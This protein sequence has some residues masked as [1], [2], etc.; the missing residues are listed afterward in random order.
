MF[1]VVV[2]CQEELEHA[3][4][5]GSRF[6]CLCDGSFVLPCTFGI[7]YS[8]I[9]T[10]SASIDLSPIGAMRNNI[11]FSGFTPFFTK[12]NENIKL[13]A[14][15]IYTVCR[16]GSAPSSAS[17]F[18]SSYTT[19]YATSY[20]HEYEYEFEY[21]SGSFLTSYLGSFSSYSSSGSFAVYRD[22]YAH[23]I[24]PDVVF[25]NGYGVNLI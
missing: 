10:V 11:S 25:V 17:S 19:S 4:E 9:G 24:N 1:D 15:P 13:L 21:R 8:A 14:S 18:K 22:P 2:F 23:I 20:F 3:I 6:I 5:N 12:K 16:M 7:S